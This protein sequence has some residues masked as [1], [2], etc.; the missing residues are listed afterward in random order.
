MT[1][2]TEYLQQEKKKSQNSNKTYSAFNMT[3]QS[4]W[5]APN[6]EQVDRSFNEYAR[7]YNTHNDQRIHGLKYVPPPKAENL[8]QLYQEQ[9]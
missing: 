3:Q 1:S 4:G 2:L 5:K 7:F 9:I 6:I 8:N